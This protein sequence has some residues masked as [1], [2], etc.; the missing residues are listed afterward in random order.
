[1]IKETKFEDI[2]EIFTGARL[3]RYQKGNTTKQPVIKKTYAENGS[4]MD[5]V[6]EEVSDEIN[7]KYYSRKDD[8]IILLTG[9]N[10]V[11]KVQD[12]GIIITMYYAIVRVKEGY[13]V[14][15]IY[16]LL[17]S[18]AFPRELTK[19]TEGTAL[20]IVKTNNLKEITLPVPDYE[21]QK[22]YGNLFNL[23][24]ERVNLYY[25]LAELEKELTKTILNDLLEGE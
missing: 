21:T 1:M 16:N 22:K 13:D 24:N 18:D 8:I 12:E 25:E 20:K 6:Y 3:T 17:K 7:P 9:S 15:F 4:Q 23:I 14:D 19:I 5:Y 2:A 11:T 10:P